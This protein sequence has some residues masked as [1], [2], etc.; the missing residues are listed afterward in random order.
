MTST[1]PTLD[2]I[3]DVRE[4]SQAIGEFLEW[5]RS[6]RKLVI[7]EDVEA[8]WT[9]EICGPVPK[10]QVTYVDWLSN[11]TAQWRHKV[12]CCKRTKEMMAER[13]SVPID[14]FHGGEVDH[15]PEGL[16]RAGVTIHALLAEYFGVDEREAEKERRALLDELRR[17]K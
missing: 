9:C 17:R 1:T 13:G 15:V 10:K 14:D 4:H 11:D 7:A 2:R 16:Y 8:S 3:A 12:K 5:L 6:E